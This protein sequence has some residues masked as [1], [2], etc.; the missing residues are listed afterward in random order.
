VS[1]WIALGEARARAA[2]RLASGR[3]EVARRV[4]LRSARLAAASPW[5]DRVSEPGA[6]LF[7][8]ASYSD[9]AAA[10]HRHV[11]ANH[12]EVR[13]YWVA[14][15]GSPDVAA[16]GAVG[17]VLLRDAL[18]TWITALRSEVQVLSHGLHDVPTASSPASRALKVR[19]G[20]G[21][22]ALKKGKPPPLRTFESANRPFG[23]VPVSSEFERANK[24]AWHIPA[25]RIVVCGV[26]RFDDLVRKSRAVPAEDRRLLY[27]PTWRDWIPKTEAGLAGS[28]FLHHVRAFLSHPRLEPLLARHGYVLE[29]YLHRLLHAPVRTLLERSGTGGRV[30]LLSGAVDVQEH[31][32]AARALVTDYSGVTWDTLYLGRPVLFY[33]FDLDAYEADRGAYFDLR[34]DLP[35]PR[36]SDADGMLDRLEAALA[37]GLALTPDALRWSERVFPWRDDRNCERVTAAIFERLGRRR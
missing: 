15:R 23:L 27:M 4:R 8:G 34:A 17:P 14:E 18:P 1:R 13:A 7:S 10:M 36:A 29:V 12:P 32:A 19:V 5:A 22:T 37:S 35:G 6:W 3:R 9:N 26:P 24:L 16:A 25:D 28:D 21:L 11:V 31:L 33:H 30:R 2:E 20:H